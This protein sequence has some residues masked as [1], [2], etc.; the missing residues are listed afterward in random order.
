V[1]Q[2]ELADALGDYRR[3]LEL[4]PLNARVQADMQRVQSAMVVETHVDPK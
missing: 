4:D 1:K 2:G 3:A